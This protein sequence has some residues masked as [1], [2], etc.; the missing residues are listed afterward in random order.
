MRGTAV[1]AT[2]L[3]V[4]AALACTGS[5]PSL[6]EA[7]TS[8]RLAPREQRL[9]A[10][11][12]I[13]LELHETVNPFLHKLLQEPPERPTAWRTVIDS[14]CGVDRLLWSRPTFDMEQ[15]GRVDPSDLPDAGK[16]AE[17]ELFRVKAAGL[18]L[19]LQG[20]A[21]KALK[22]QSDQLRPEVMQGLV[23]LAGRQV[24]IATRRVEA[25]NR[26]SQDYIANAADSR[27]QDEQCVT[28][29]VQLALDA[30]EL[31][32]NRALADEIATGRPARVVAAVDMDAL[33]KA[34]DQFQQAFDAARKRNQNN[35]AAIAKIRDVASKSETPQLAKS[36]SDLVAALQ[37]AK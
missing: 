2:A 27:I 15:R 1:F 31:A 12:Q 33:L 36:R 13:L 7:Q 18:E 4:M 37:R 9:L 24:Q 21:F 35:A 16:W 30:I 6:A 28:E 5:V 14:G 10:A 19:D 3:L 22:S 34:R 11:T 32:R 29:A 25:I 26:R 17:F 23:D 8:G 20:Q